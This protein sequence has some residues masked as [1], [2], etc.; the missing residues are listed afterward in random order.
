M[1]IN[2]TVQKHPEAWQDQ[3]SIESIICYCLS[4]GTKHVGEGNH[5][6]ARLYA[7]LARYLEEVI[8]VENNI[9]NDIY[10]T[11]TKL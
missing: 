2:A 10:R 3:A 8:A 9:Q 6:R 5:N 11:N 7:A 1:E 4:K